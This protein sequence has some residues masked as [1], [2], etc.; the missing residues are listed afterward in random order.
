MSWRSCRSAGMPPASG[1]VSLAY[2]A[3]HHC[4]DGGRPAALRGGITGRR[5]GFRCIARRRSRLGYRSARGAIRPSTAALSEVPAVVGRPLRLTAVH[6]RA[7]DTL[8]TQISAPTKRPLSARRNQYRHAVLRL[9]LEQARRDDQAVRTVAILVAGP[10]VPH[11]GHPPTPTEAGQL[12]ARTP[13]LTDC[14]RCG[15]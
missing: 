12:F 4:A 15:C 14:P 8:S 13:P 1:R 5:S 10:K 6:I 9:A 2:E 7:F 3:V 11:R